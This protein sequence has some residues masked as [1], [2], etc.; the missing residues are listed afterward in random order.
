M[1]DLTNVENIKTD[2][3]AAINFDIGIFAS[4]YE[5][6]AIHFARQF[7][8]LNFDKTLVLGFKEFNKVG[9]REDNDD[10]FRQKF[11]EILE[12]SSQE[13]KSIYD[14]LIIFFRE[15]EDKEDIVVF[16]DYTSMARIWYSGILNFLRFQ[17]KGKVEVYVNYSLGEYDTTFLDYKYSAISSVPFHE[18]T[19]SA[20]TKTLLVLALGFSPYLIKSVIEEIEPNQS[21]GVLPIPDN[22]N[23]NMLTESIKGDILV[24]DID[25]WYNCSIIDL[26]SIFSTYAHIS[27]NNYNTKDILFLSLG[28]KIFTLASLLVAQR[29]PQVTC[30]YLKSSQSEKFD[31]KPSGKLVCNKITYQ[32]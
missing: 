27:G 25:E 4:G 19:L 14:S 2:E 26:E 1:L 5:S 22:A 29:F 7:P 18:G 31:V 16:M 13:E 23:H 21:I 8:L 15:L 28:P 24:K 12:V 20:N 6:R 32:S 11:G 17:K 30:L 3:L 9:G 10:F